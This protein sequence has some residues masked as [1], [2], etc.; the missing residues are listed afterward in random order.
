[1]TASDSLM[2]DLL[3][4]SKDRGGF[5]FTEKK[6]SENYGYYDLDLNIFNT[7]GKRIKYISFSVKALNGVGD[8]VGAI[9]TFK[10]TG[11]VEH[12]SSGSWE[13]DTGWRIDN[14]NSVKI[15]TVK[16]TYEDGSLKTIPGI[17]ILQLNTEQDRERLVIYC[18]KLN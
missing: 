7:S 10:G 9:K 17:K 14:I 4:K 5:I 11:W 12:M 16:I 15:E 1:M 8:P 18:N 6:L 3:I 2:N 13:F